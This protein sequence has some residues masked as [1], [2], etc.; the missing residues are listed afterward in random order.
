MKDNTENT[1]LRPTVHIPVAEHE[2]AEPENL[3]PAIK[4]ENAEFDAS[5]T[6]ASEETD[7]QLSAPGK[8]FWFVV[9][10]LV[11]AIVQLAVSLY[12]AFQAGAWLGIAW[13]SLLALGGVAMGVSLVRE[14]RAFARLEQR[15]QWQQT[16]GRL[17]QSPAI[18]EAREY[19]LELANQLP[20]SAQPEVTSWL[21]HLQPHYS[22]KEI[23]ALFEQQVLGGI[24]KKV[25][26]QI[27]HE[28][29]ASAV[30][31]AVSPFALLDMLLVLWRNLKMINQISRSYGVQTGYWAR[32][33]LIRK[34]CHNIIYAGASELAADA[35][36]WALGGSLTAKLS[37]R[38]AQGLGAG[39]LTARMGVQAARLCRPMPFMQLPAPST[40][41]IASQVLSRLKK[42][43]PDSDAEH[44]A[45]SE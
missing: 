11:M 30:L 3:R 14:W 2:N 41:K 9:L 1:G 13:L 44:K 4:I 45:G 39:V 17:A 33:R 32:I 19:C 35:S 6:A 31:I 7:N 29:S 25:M 21:S 24:D 40:S 5:V 22:D 8:L 28:A 43:Q 12:G 37:S 36:V 42:M 26:S 18:G 15:S 16:C 27:S 23:I 10:L 38:V 34:M 20:D